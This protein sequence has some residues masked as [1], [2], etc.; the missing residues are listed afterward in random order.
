MENINCSILEFPVQIG[1]MLDQVKNGNSFYMQAHKLL[2]SLAREF[3]E[4]I[5]HSGGLESFIDKTTFSTIG[6]QFGQVQLEVTTN[7]EGNTGSLESYTFRLSRD[8][9]Y[10]TFI[11]AYEKKNRIMSY[12][13]VNG[14]LKDFMQFLGDLIENWDSEKLIER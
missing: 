2:S 12:R 5:Y 10:V 8:K 4:K 3:E 1:Q 7:P 11:C 14:S 9:N 6:F 13:D